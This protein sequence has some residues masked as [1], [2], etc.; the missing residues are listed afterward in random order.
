M[1]ISEANNKLKTYTGRLITLKDQ[2]F[3]LESVEEDHLVLRNED[4]MHMFIWFSSIQ[5]VREV[6]GGPPEI[7]LP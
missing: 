5:S 3:T 1:E 6:P 4:Q 2:T 7:I